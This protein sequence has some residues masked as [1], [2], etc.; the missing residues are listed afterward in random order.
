MGQGEVDDVEKQSLMHEAEDMGWYW[1]FGG[2]SGQ[3]SRTKTQH[4][5][6]VWPRLCED[7]SL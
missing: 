6:A 3:S 2:Q 1:H 5:P 4:D 7:T